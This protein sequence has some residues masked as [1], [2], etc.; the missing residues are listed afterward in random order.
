MVCPV[1]PGSFDP[2]HNGHLD[3]IIRAQRIFGDLMVL[4]MENPLKSKSR[5]TLVER[6]AIVNESISD[7][8]GARATSFEGSL[9]DYLRQE[10][11]KTVIKGLRGSVDVD[12]EMQMAQINRHLGRHVETLFLPT[13]PSL[14]FVTGTRIRELVDLG[15]DVSTFVPKVTRRKLEGS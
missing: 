11:T 9:L 14:S 8:E 12:S 6:L 7:I 2:L 5:F 10:E 1:F 13:D 4:V 3:I 15:V